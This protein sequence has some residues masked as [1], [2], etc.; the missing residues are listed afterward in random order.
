MSKIF[1]KILNIKTANKA[2]IDTIVNIKTHFHLKII[3][4]Y[5]NIYNKN[6]LNYLSL[7]LFRFLNL[8]KQI[9]AIY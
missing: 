8:C 6:Y 1:N 3:N 4:N 5:M 9:F 2:L 7:Q